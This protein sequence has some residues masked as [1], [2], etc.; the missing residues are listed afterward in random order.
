VDTAALERIA[1]P[2]LDHARQRGGVLLVNELGH[3]W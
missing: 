2:A 3:H 1:L